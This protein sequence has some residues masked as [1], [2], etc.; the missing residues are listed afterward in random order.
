LENR[1]IIIRDGRILEKDTIADPW[2]Q[3]KNFCITYVM[4]GGFRDMHFETEN[5]AKFKIPIWQD[6]LMLNMFHRIAQG[7]GIS[8]DKIELYQND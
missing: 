4:L 3:M 6:E 1:I 5:D 2:I 8:I 7:C